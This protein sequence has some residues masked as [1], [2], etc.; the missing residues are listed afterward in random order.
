MKI[1]S[2]NQSSI[3]LLKNPVSLQ[4]AKHIDVVH[5]FARERVMRGDIEFSYVPTEIHPTDEFMLADGNLTASPR[6]WVPQSTSSALLAWELAKVIMIDD[7][8]DD[9]GG[10]MRKC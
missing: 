9:Y 7:L 2:D 1:L 6:H 10:V 3:K 5:H 4:R 8:H